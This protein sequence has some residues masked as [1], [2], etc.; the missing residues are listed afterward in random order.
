[1]KPI[2]VGYFELM[3]TPYEIGHQM[4]E[5]LERKR[6]VLPKSMVLPK[7]DA[8]AAMKLY[9]TFCP[10]MSEEMKGYADA[11]GTE[12]ERLV[13]VVMTYLR[14]RCSQMAL[15]PQLTEKGHTILARSYEFGPKAEDFHLF[16]TKVKGKYSHIGGS[17]VEFGRSE[18]LNECGLGV[19][20]SSCGLPVSNLKE[21]R[22]PAL[23]GLQFWAV[24]RTL[25]ENCKDVKEAVDCARKMPI[26]Y[27]IN[28]LTVDKGGHAALI[29]TFDGRFASQSIGDEDEVKFLHATNHAHLKEMIAHEPL[30]KHHSR[31]RYNRIRHFLSDETKKSEEELKSFLLTEYPAG[32][33]CHF[34]QDFFGTIKSIIMD[35]NDGRFTVCW[36]GLVEN[37][38]KDYNIQKPMGNHNFTIRLKE[39]QA[40]TDCDVLEKIE[41]LD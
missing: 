3:G 27:N 20:M 12:V 38:W 17:V 4:G 34:Y 11:V 18:G 21:M 6:M 30:A 33:N 35:L 7:A 24:I 39:A 25:L 19:S 36:G 10:G 40:P 28:L 14:P 15:L 9:D 13:Y 1:M 29:E 41:S 22:A 23:S 26:A 2:T 16:R 8:I 37:G 32:L 5:L 31:V